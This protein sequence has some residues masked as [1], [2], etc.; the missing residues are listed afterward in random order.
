MSSFILTNYKVNIKVIPLV[1]A[2]TRFCPI[3]SMTY[4][5]LCILMV[6]TINVTYGNT[7]CPFPNGYF[8]CI[9]GVTVTILRIPAPP[10][11]PLDSLAYQR[12]PVNP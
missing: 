5:V 1:P 10:P 2:R 9:W 12:Q 8:F 7:Y 6:Q 11:P 3:K 4:V